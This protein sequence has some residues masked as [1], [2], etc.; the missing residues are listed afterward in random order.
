A[1][2]LPS[3]R[4][5]NFLLR[6]ALGERFVLKIANAE[7]NFDF[8]NFQNH[9]IR[10]LAAQNLDLEFPRIVPAR[11]GEDL[12]LITT[13][14]SQHFVRLLTW[15]DGY[16]FAEIKHPGRKLLA[17]LGRALAQMD[18]ALDGFSHQS[19]HRDFLWDLRNAAAR[20]LAGLLPDDRRRL[21]ERFFAEWEKVDWGSLRFSII[22]NDAN[23][24][25][26][27]VR[28]EEHRV[29]AIID[30]GDVVHS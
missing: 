14:D 20:D 23:D 6:T 26:I 5:Q 2:A 19:A 16:C 12:A 21:V 10:F 15:L 13:A 8:L 27:L 1:S 4:D 24:Y 29:K 18:A 28:S 30:Y 22:H 25:N 7:E 17:S 3:E 11:N 9:L